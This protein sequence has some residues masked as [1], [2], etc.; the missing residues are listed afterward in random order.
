[1][2][3]NDFVQTIAG[4]TDW[5]HTD[6]IKLFAWFL[7]T[8]AGLSRFQPTHLRECFT[9]LGIAP[10]PSGVGPF[11][12]DLERKKPAQVVQDRDGYYLER[13]VRDQ[14]ERKYGHRAITVQV[15]ETLRDL[16]N[17]LPNLPERTY[18][19]ESLTCF[20]HGAFR[21]SVV[22][23]WNLVYDHLCDHILN[24][25]L[26]D[27]N[28][29]LPRRFPKADISTVA[30]RDD[31]HELKESQVLEVCRTA[32]ITTKN[33]HGVLKSSLDVRNRVAH[34]SGVT[35]L[36]PQAESFILD[37]INNALFQL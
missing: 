8:H 2:T 26:A 17:K 24:K 7:H 15:H 16:P 14:F 22:M 9:Q 23:C 28:S 4:F 10:P 13:T 6:K 34:A 29:T 30:N 32:G 33:V 25:R 1:V 18:L 12:R 11:L 35:F 31:F 27:F 20:Q 19:E 37:V 3:L 36:Q 21:A 5:G